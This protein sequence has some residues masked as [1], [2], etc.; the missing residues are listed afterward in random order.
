MHN[1]IV[2]S[3][4]VLLNVSFGGG[5]LGWALFVALGF[6]LDPVF[7]RIGPGVPLTGSTSRTHVQGASNAVRM[8]L[9]LERDSRSCAASAPGCRLTA[10]L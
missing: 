7:D 9:P 5:M 2:F 6:I 8:S 4:M 3:L 10:R 1:L